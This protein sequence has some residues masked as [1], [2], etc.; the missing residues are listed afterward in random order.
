MTATYDLHPFQRLYSISQAYLLIVSPVLLHSIVA[1]LARFV[2]YTRL[3]SSAHQHPRCFHC[4]IMDTLRIAPTPRT[5][6][7]RVILPPSYYTNCTPSIRIHTTRNISPTVHTQ[8]T[9]QTLLLPQPANQY[10]GDVF[11][12]K[13]IV[14]LSL[15]GSADIRDACLKWH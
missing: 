13:E 3:S 11:E 4:N 14:C 1:M 5:H 6:S 7:S 12:K 15:A 9:Y 8:D 10:I 2:H